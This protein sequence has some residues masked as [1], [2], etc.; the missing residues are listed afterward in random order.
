M[1]E[2][3]TPR[4]TSDTGKVAPSGRH[5]RVLVVSDD[6]EAK[7]LTRPMNF[8]TKYL[9]LQVDKDTSSASEKAIFNYPPTGTAHPEHTVTFK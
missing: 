2:Y 5:V 3:A 9:I 8:I 1:R 7:S 4:S 6:R